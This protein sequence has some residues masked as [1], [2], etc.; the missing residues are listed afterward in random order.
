MIKLNTIRFVIA[1]AFLFISLSSWANC[2]NRDTFKNLDYGLYWYGVSNEC[3]QA[4]PGQQNTYFDPSKPTVIHIH[5]WQSDSVTSMSRTTFNAEDSGGP[6]VDTAF[7]WR[8]KGWNIGILYWNQFA[9]ESEVKDAEA[10]IWTANGPQSMRW[11]NVDGEYSNGPSSDVTTLLYNSLVNNM[12]DFRGGELR[13]TGHSLGNQLALRISQRLHQESSNNSLKPKRLALL[14]AFYSNGEKDYLNGAWVGERA[15]GIVD[16][17]IENGVVVE[18]YRSSAISDTVFAG[19]SNYELMRKTA[20]T[21]IRPWYFNAFQ[22]AEK[23]NAAVWH[24]FWSFE[25]DAPISEPDESIA[26][27]SATELNRARELMTGNQKM[28]HQHGRYTQSPIDDI[29]AYQQ[30]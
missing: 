18:A 14:D 27:S 28:I 20:F 26:M 11:L 8:D 15:R 21:E 17:L 22:F 19:D 3:E 5:G 10:K 30:K 24:Y 16:D 7:A 25:F 6:F 13:I 12:E 4:T 9:D 2:F 29:M 23:H 1:T